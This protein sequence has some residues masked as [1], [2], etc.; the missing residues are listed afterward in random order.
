MIKLLSIIKLL[1][2]CY[3]GV[4]RGYIDVIWRYTYSSITSFADEKESNKSQ[5]RCVFLYHEKSIAKLSDVSHYIN[6][7]C[8]RLETRCS[9]KYCVDILNI[10]VNLYKIS[11]LS[12]ESLQQ[13]SRLVWI[14]LDFINNSYRKILSK[15]CLK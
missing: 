11:C 13:V 2:G 5:K 10:F 1:Q 15:N 4:V 12:L 6:Y 9:Q 8:A 7:G 14:C 3:I